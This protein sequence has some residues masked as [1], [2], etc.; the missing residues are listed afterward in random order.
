MRAPSASFRRFVTRA[1]ALSAKHVL[2]TCRDRVTFEDD[3]RR[4]RFGEPINTAASFVKERY[5]CVY[6]YEYLT[7]FLGTSLY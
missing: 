6:S 5:V 7:L 3:R 4:S 1:L 2:A